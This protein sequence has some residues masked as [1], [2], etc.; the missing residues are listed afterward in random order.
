[1]E[2]TVGLKDLGVPDDDPIA[3]RTLDPDSQEARDVLA[4]VDLTDAVPRPPEVDGM[5]PDRVDGRR[6]AWLD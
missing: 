4:D 1:M 3:G 6:D 5:G 2:R